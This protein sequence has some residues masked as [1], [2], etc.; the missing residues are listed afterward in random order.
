[1]D[2]ILFERTQKHHH[3]PSDELSN[4]VFE[5]VKI[6]LDIIILLRL[7]IARMCTNVHVFHDLL[8]RHFRTCLR[9]CLTFLIS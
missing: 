7:K 2:A 9:E 4:F 6:V 8:S 3:R 5:A 1:M